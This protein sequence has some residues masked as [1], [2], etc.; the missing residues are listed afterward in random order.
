MSKDDLYNP[1]VKNNLLLRTEG[2]DKWKYEV[3]TAEKMILGHQCHLPQA[4]RELAMELKEPE[5]RVDL[6]CIKAWMIPKNFCCKCDRTDITNSIGPDGR[7]RVP[8][9]GQW[10]VDVPMPGLDITV[11][12]V[13]VYF[14]CPSCAQE[15]VWGAGSP[16]VLVGLDGR[17]LQ[18]PSEIYKKRTID[19]LYSMKLRGESPKEIGSA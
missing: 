10:I 4:Q 12:D 15:S 11:G 14:V 3:E 18:D 13:V 16:G 6:P 5:N 17:P 7:V 19:Y 8:S 2:E 1:E 9:D